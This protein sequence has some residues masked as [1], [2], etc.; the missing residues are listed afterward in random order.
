MDIGTQK[1]V[2][3]VEEERVAPVSPARHGRE[4]KATGKE[5]IPQS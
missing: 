3:I 1:R 4:D 2:I 5:G